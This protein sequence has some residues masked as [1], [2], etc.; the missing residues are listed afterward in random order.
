MT[1]NFDDLSLIATKVRENPRLKPLALWLADIASEEASKRDPEWTFEKWKAKNP[2]MQSIHGDLLK[3]EFLDDTH[4][5]LDHTDKWHFKI[6]EPTTSE[7]VGL[8]G[9]AITGDS[10]YLYESKLTQR[11]GKTSIA[12]R[13]PDIKERLKSSGFEYDPQMRAWRYVIG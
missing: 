1:S 10:H 3:F 7:L 11:W 2:G 12:I 4:S 13:F 6:L 5:K 9:G 8:I